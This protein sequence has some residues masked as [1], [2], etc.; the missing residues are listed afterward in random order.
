MIRCE[1]G[2]LGCAT[3]Q[4]ALKD[5]LGAGETEINKYIY[6]T[7]AIT[8]CEGYDVVKGFETEAAA[9]AFCTEMRRYDERK[10]DSPEIDAPDTEWED[11]TEWQIHFK[12]GHPA[13]IYGDA[14]GYSVLRVK[15]V[16]A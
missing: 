16:S 3:S 13:G 7:I 11:Y 9:E 5:V 6:L 2:K 1:R 12:E 10:R 8:D 14:D 15:I 4:S